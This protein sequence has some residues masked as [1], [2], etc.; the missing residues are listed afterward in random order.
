MIK[1]D[2]AIRILVKIVT[3][4]NK[5]PL[6]LVGSLRRMAEKVKDIDLML[7]VGN[8]E[9]L[10]DINIIFLSNIEKQVGG[11]RR[12][13]YIVDGV[14]IDIFIVR[15]NEYPYAMLHFTGPAS[16]N[17]RIRALCKKNGLTLNQYGLF[18]GDKKLE[19]NIKTES[20]LQ[21]YLGITVRSPSN[22]L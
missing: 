17:I 22:R 9:K 10:S 16:Y 6:V 18:R 15:E 19:L 20:D 3:S 14:P 21:Q 1:Y 2:V 11:E 13:S 12:K 7:I 5:G 8:D 4:I